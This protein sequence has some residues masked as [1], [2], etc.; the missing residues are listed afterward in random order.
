MILPNAFGTS[1]NPDIL[2][3]IWILARGGNKNENIYDRPNKRSN[4]NR[5]TD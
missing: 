1:L 5:R 2:N 4:D 3:E